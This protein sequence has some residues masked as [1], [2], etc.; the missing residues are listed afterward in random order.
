M[1]LQTL[2]T[3]LEQ[4]VKRF[5][6]S[7]IKIGQLFN[8]IKESGVYKEA[9][10]SY[11]GHYYS[12]RWEK[13]IGRSWATAKG[14][15]QAGR[16]VSEMSNVQ[17][18]EHPVSD[19]MAAQRLNRIEEPAERVKVWNEHVESG[20][21]RA[22]YQNL[23]R[24]IREHKGELP[25]PEEPTVSQTLSPEAIESAPS[26]NMSAE[27]DWFHRTG[28]IAGALDQL[29]PE[30]VADSNEE[31]DRI[32][33]AIDQSRRIIDWYE[34]YQQVLIAKRDQ[35]AKLRAVR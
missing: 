13:R 2:E 15:M 30:E 5:D 25:K 21:K 17:D 32:E 31:Y 3:Q 12:A 26:K 23:D 18:L 7:A 19:V 8:Q 22:G 4:E 9:G 6:N 27:L 34:R 33:R 11:F 35:G 20:E 28:R 14:Y 24:R 1:D 16:V 10:F 29:E